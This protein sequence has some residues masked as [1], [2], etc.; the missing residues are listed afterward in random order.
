MKRGLLILSVL[1]S[2]MMAS[3]QIIHEVFDVSMGSKEQNAFETW[4]SKGVTYTQSPHFKDMYVI[5]GKDEKNKT[6]PTT[7][8]VFFLNH[9]LFTVRYT[10]PKDHYETICDLIKSGY[11]K[12][13][14][15]QDNYYKGYYDETTEQFIN[16]GKTEDNT[17][18]TFGINIL[19]KPGK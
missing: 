11:A 15:F 10:Y 13:F 9:R 12:F 18:L 3:A 14:K 4:K 16:I 2:T 17:F 19:K 5:T 8:E 7:I 6:N 1:L